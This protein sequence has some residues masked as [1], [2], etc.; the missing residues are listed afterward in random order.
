MRTTGSTKARV[1]II[2]AGP[3]GLTSVKNLIEVGAHDITCFDEGLA[4]GG[5]WVFDESHLRTSVYESTHIISSKAWSSFEDFPMPGEYPDFP[6]H[7]QMRAYFESYAEH[8]CLWPHIRLRTRVERASLRK[9]GLWS[10]STSGPDG[11]REQVFDYLIVCSGH[12]REPFIPTYPGHFSGEALHSCAFKRAEPF[13]GK[14]VLVVGAGNSACDIAVEIARVA[15]RTCISLRRG[16]YIV[17][18]VIFGRPVDVLYARLRQKL[19]LP[20]PVLQPLLRT[21]LR[22]GIGPW[23][24]YGLPRPACGPLEMHATLNSNILNALRDGT[25]LT[26][27]AIERLDG[28]LVHFNDGRKEIF[29]TIIWATGFQLSFAFLDSSVV[30]WGSL[31]TPPLYLRMMHRRIANLFFIGLFQPMGCIWR[32]ADLQAR[33]AALQ[34]TGKFQRPS[35]IGVRVDRELRSPHWHFDQAPRHSIEVDYHDFHRDL[36]RALSS[37]LSNK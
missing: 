24:K 6:S 25:V 33:I 31:T 20:R 28:A 34:I 12:H 21:F 7:R 1:C 15:E 18:K 3:C 10:V 32:L 27:A 13:R 17:P 11:S 19:R 8:F 5:N 14:R 9:E 30:D 35:D 2:G 16:Y 37:M 36:V 26:R 22:I 4:I 29:D 23:E